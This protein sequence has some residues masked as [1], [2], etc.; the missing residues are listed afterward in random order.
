[1]KYLPRFAFYLR[2]KN[3]L[4]KE[5]KSRYTGTSFSSLY[6]PEDFFK[7]NIQHDVRQIAF[8]VLYKHQSRC[9]KKGTPVID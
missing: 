3:P 9:E 6:E 1:M 2:K 4:E 7:L 8:Y 5:I